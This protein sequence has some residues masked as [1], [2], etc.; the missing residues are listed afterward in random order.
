MRLW[1]D[2]QVAVVHFAAEA[3]TDPTT[4]WLAY[5]PLG[6]M[7]VGFATGVIVPGHVYKQVLKEN[8][9][10]HSLIDEKVYP[11]VEANAR[12]TEQAIEALSARRAR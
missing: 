5:G 12:A 1:T 3:P 10:L 8:E 11:T 6:L 4:G 2:L 9:R 7:V